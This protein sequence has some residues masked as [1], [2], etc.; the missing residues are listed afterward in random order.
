M[1]TPA[2][3]WVVPDDND[4]H[5]Q[6]DDRYTDSLNSLVARARRGD[7]AAWTDIVDR[8]MPLVRAVVRA[9]RLSSHDAEDVNQIV[10]LRL[11]ERLDTI[12]RADAMPGWMW[13]VTRNECVSLIRRRNRVLPSREDDIL[14]RLECVDDASSDVLKDEAIQV[15]LAGMTH[16]SNRDRELLSLLVADPPLRYDEIGLRLDMP[17]GSIGPTRARALARLRATPP[18]AAWFDNPHT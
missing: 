14:V 12:A 17:I 6:D 16:L 11:F 5:H 8:F 4:Q 2:A 18:M 15:V 9:H 3:S 1:T 7:Q 13:T 10:W